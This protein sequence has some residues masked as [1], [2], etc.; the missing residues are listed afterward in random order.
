MMPYIYSLAYKRYFED[1]TIMRRLVMISSD[2]EKYLT[3]T[4]TVVY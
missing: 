4:T 1:Y 2:D 3:Y